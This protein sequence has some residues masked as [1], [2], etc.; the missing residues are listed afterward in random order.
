ML[1][2]GRQ[3]QTKHVHAKRAGGKERKI[4]VCRALDIISIHGFVKAK[5]TTGFFHLEKRGELRDML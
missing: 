5:N 4:G 2:E 3:P 1:N